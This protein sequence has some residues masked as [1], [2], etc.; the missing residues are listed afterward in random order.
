MARVAVPPSWT[1]FYVGAGWG[2]GVSDTNS[3]VV[4]ASGAVQGTTNNGARG[5]LGMADAGYDY[6]FA[7]GGWISWPACS[8]ITILAT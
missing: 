7:V 2:Y 3:S 4:P 1:G 6:Q 5:W 8:A